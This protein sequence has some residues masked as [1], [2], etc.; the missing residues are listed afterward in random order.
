M[1]RWTSPA[2]TVGEHLKIGKLLSLLAA[3][4]VGTTGLHAQSFFTNLGTDPSTGVDRGSASNI[5]KVDQRTGFLTFSSIGAEEIGP[6]IASATIAWPDLLR[7]GDQLDLV[8]VLG[9]LSESGGLE[10]EAAGLGYRQDLPGTGVTL[11]FNADHGAYELGSASSLALDIGGSQTNAAIG[12]RKVWALSDNARLTGSLELALRDSRNEILGTV[13]SEERLRML[14]AALKLERGRPFL[15]QQ[16]YGVSVTKGFDGFGAS[17]SGSLS[18][19]APGVAT[20]FL[21]LAYSAEASVPLSMRFLVNAGVVGQWTTDSLPVSQRCGYGTNAY[22]RGFDQ[23]YV[24]GDRCLGTRVE[25]AYNLLLPDPRA[26]MLDLRQAFVG[27]DGGS[28]EDLA[29]AVVPGT[30]DRWSSVSAG[31]R[32]ARGDFLGEVSVTHILDEPAGAFPQDETRLWLQAAIR[33]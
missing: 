17:P 24:N 2:L 29:N 4:L 25:L 19:S 13:Y 5:R 28:I 22:A 21:R 1:V 26:K 15:F 32:M 18:G 11:Y 33:F 27:L 23:S 7:T 31:V 3:I 9:G 30:S 20:D 6:Y 12:A 14:R 10:L 16:R 8:L